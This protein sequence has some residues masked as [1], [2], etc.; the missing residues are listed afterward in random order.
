MIDVVAIL[1]ICSIVL[2]ILFFIYKRF[3]KEVIYLYQIENLDKEEIIELMKISF[4]RNQIDM[5][6]MEIPKIYNSM[7]YRIFFTVHC[8]E[9]LIDYNSG[10]IQSNLHLSFDKLNDSDGKIEYCCTISD[11]SNCEIDLLERIHEKYKIRR[12]YE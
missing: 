1:I 7:F 5:E 4:I 10:K 8:L 2:I 12:S 11:Y 9:D 3:K 6:K